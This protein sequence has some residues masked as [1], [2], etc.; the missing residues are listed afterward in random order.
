MAQTLIDQIE[1]E[2]IRVD[3]DYRFGKPGERD[4][5]LAAY[6]VLALPV[7]DVRADEL[8]N[9]IFEDAGRTIQTS[10]QLA[11]WLYQRLKRP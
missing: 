9:Q 8:A 5:V 1:R 3:S 2:I 6:R 4:F 7:D 11:E 10:K